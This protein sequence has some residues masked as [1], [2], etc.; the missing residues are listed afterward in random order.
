MNKSIKLIALD[1]DGTLLNDEHQVMPKTAEMIQ[2]AQQSG[3]RVVLAT[4]RGPRSCTHL[5]EALALK[6]P[7]IAHNGAVIYDPHTLEVS[8]EIGYS[9]LELLP[10]IQYCR[11]KKIQFDLSTAF[12]MY[13]E[14]KTKEAEDLYVL[15]NVHPEIVSDSSQLKDQIVKCTLFGTP[16][17]LDQAL[18]DLQKLFP[19]WSILRSGDIF[20]DIIHP[21]ATKGFGLIQVMQELDIQEE[22]VMAFGNYFNDIEMLKAAGIGVAMENSPDEVKSIADYVTGTNN[23]EGIAEFLQKYM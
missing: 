20:I 4:G 8:L 5:V 10:I 6:G 23:E 9:A 21:K 7:I 3:V 15:F 12:D 17:Q 22:E 16:Q 19:E 14:G 11:A 1:V 13:I 18:S 2:K